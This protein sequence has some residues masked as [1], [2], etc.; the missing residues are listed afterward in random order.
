MRARGTPTS[1]RRFPVPP[2]HRGEASPGRRGWSDTVPEKRE[3][4]LD[5]HDLSDAERGRHEHG[6]QRVRQ[7]VPDEGA[8][9]GAPV[10][11]AADTKSLSCA[12]TVL[13]RTSRLALNHPD[14]A[15]QMR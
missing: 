11:R 4:G 3:T 6:R 14:Q 10:A 15:E 5:D 7:N 9:V 8:S 1:T 12:S 13:T 2:V